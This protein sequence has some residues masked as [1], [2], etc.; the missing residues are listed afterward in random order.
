MCPLSFQGATLI[1]PDLWFS[2]IRLSD[3]SCPHRARP[4][5]LGFL[6]C[7]FKPPSQ[8][9]QCVPRPYSQS[10]LIQST[11]HRNPV[12][13]A[14]LP[15]PVEFCCLL[16]YFGT[17]PAS[18][19]LFHP[20]AGIGGHRIALLLCATGPDRV[21]LGQYRTFP[22]APSLTTQQDSQGCSPIPLSACTGTQ[23]LCDRGLHHLPK[24]GRHCQATTGSQFVTAHSFAS[25]P[26]DST[27]RWT[28][29]HCW[30]SHLNG[31]ICRSRTFT[32]KLLYLPVAR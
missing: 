25:G 1:E 20:R 11:V 5:G 30:L 26:P 27:L 16:R 10:H 23:N 18:D 21:S 22:S 29:C 14:A 9:P 8:G 7:G 28:P 2:H 19:S 31:V 4:C 32:C 13:V 15:I 3:D 17:M 12:E 24:V 6:C